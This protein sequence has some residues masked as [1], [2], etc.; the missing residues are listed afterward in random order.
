MGRSTL[1][2]ERTIRA[3]LQM[4]FDRITD[5]EAMSDWP[6][7][8]KCW[9]VAE[10]TPRN[11]LG[12]VRAVKARGLTLHEKVVLFEPPNCFEYTIIKGLPVDHLGSVS[13]AVDNDGAG[14]GG[15]DV[16]RL[17]WHISISSRV[18]LLARIMTWQ[19]RTG[20]PAAVDYFIAET[21]RAARSAA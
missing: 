11:G 14:D 8:S 16:V 12:A 9:L 17:R 10:G 1:T 15:S 7:V 19:L 13:L 21:E 18:P 5:H 2:L 4:V 3:P 6:G 20:L